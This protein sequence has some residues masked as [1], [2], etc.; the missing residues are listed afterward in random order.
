MGYLRPVPFSRSTSWS[1]HKRRRQPSTEAGID[2]FCPIG[3]PVLAIESG[4]IADTGDSI[5]PATGRFVTLDLDDGRRARFLHL[6]NRIVKIGDRVR[7]GQVIGYSGATGY[8]EEDWSWNVAETGG[9]HVHMTLWPSQRYVF[10]ATGTLDPELYFDT[11]GTTA[12]NN[13]KPFE[14]DDMYNE[15][16]R[17]RDQR[18]ASFIDTLKPMVL[19]G[20]PGV[21]LS[22]AR[23]DQAITAVLD[24]WSRFVVD[25]DG[26]GTKDYDLMQL[27]NNELKP[28]L[29]TLIAA[30]GRPSG[31]P[32]APV[33]VEALADA[34]RE[35][36]SGEIVTELAARLAS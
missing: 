26:N 15:D 18:V 12:G 11:T 24:L 35:G 20:E 28:M 30:V 25:V 29:L 10:G 7:R 6:R 23:L 17:A 19:N 1:A 16:D 22:R 13:A 33:N 32:G 2:M 5:G 14:E 34:I 9:A 4:R 21:D 3:T 36:L 31:E 27:T 8:G